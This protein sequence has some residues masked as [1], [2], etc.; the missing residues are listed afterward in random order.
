MAI[1]REQIGPTQHYKGRNITAH[2]LSIDVQMR[3]DGNDAGIFLSAEAGRK[4]IMKSIDDED[5]REK[6]SGDS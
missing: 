6:R 4:A 1:E 5:A 2:K 3:I